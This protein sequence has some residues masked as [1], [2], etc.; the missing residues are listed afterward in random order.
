MADAASG[1]DG[2]ARLTPKGAIF[3]KNGAGSGPA[4]NPAGE[5]I[6]EVPTYNSAGDTTGFD[7]M[8]RKSFTAPSRVVYR[9]KNAITRAVWGPDGSI[10]VL[11]GSHY[12]G[13]TGPAPEVFTISKS[14]KIT[15][16]H[17]DLPKDLGSVTWNERGGGLGIGT[18][19]NKGEVVYG[20]TRSYG[21]PSGWTPAT[22]NSAGTQ[23]MVWG[24]GQ[25]IGFW[26]PAKPDSIKGH[27][28][29][30]KAA[31]VRRDRLARRAGEAVSQA[32]TSLN[33]KAWR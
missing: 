4:I 1:Y 21:L 24:P 19:G 5:I 33:A 26:S 28:I 31:G 8:A 20:A 3:L 25:Q 29:A 10:A 30:G 12:P 2:I 16:I 9:Q 6:D 17:A 11:S 27:R 32:R 22:W 14:G 13:T 23:L 7:L 15:M 18:W